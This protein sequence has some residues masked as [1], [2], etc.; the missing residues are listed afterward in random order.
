MK[1]MNDNLTLEDLGTMSGLTLR[2]LRYYI[3]EGIL[4]GPDTHG[5]FS[6]YSQ[7][8]L[9]RLEL[10][11]RLKSLRLPLQEIRHLLENM[12]PEELSQV[13]QYQDVLKFT[14]QDSF[15]ENSA[16]ESNKEGASALEY[17]QNLERG[18]ESVRSISNPMPAPRPSPQAPSPSLFKDAAS[19]KQQSTPRTQETWSRTILHDGIELNIRHPNNAVEQKK[20]QQLL[21][22]AKSIFGDQSKREK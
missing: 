18:R 19:G 16:P 12:T 7:Q 15:L 14:L 11:Q 13:K 9:D 21:D 5:K 8:H 3:Q 2:T 1:T 17:I 6:R 22:F 20:I 4:Q 10:I